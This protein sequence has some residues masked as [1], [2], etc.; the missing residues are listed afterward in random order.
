MSPTGRYFIKSQEPQKPYLVRKGTDNAALPKT[1]VFIGNMLP[2][3]RKKNEQFRSQFLEWEPPLSHRHRLVNSEVAQRS[4]K[5][6]KAFHSNCA[7][8]H[9][10]R[11]WLKDTGICS[12]LRVIPGS[13][14]TLSYVR[15]PTEHARSEYPVLKAPPLAVSVDEIGLATK[16]L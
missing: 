15:T 4:W 11:R 14:V 12:C 9:L 7:Q 1:N 10:R 3:E 5:P 13:Q 8:E 16:M 6:Y 2:K